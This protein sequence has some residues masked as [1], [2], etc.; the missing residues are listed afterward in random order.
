MAE[1]LSNSTDSKP[2][3]DK[4]TMPRPLDIWDNIPEEEQREIEVFMEWACG[5]SWMYPFHHTKRTRELIASEW[6]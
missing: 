4:E 2:K 3:V 6:N 1:D 5:R